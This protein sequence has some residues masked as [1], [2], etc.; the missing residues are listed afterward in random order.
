MN[1]PVTSSIPDLNTDTVAKID[2]DDLNEQL[3]VFVVQNN[4]GNPIPSFPR[5]VSKYFRHWKSA[6]YLMGAS[7]NGYNAQ[8]NKH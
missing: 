6:G 3:V 1:S 8:Y 5:I 4:D 2:S 7:Y